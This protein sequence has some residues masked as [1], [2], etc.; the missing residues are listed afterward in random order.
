MA[1]YTVLA[2]ILGGTWIR[3]VEGETPEGALGQWAQDLDITEIEGFEETHKQ[4]LVGAVSMIDD[5]SQPTLIDGCVN[6]W[7]WYTSTQDEELVL[8]YLVETIKSA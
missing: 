2:E 7:V 1:L 5:H 6:A 4:Y 8:V 3:Q